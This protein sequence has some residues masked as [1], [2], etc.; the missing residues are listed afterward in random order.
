MWENADGDPMGL[1]LEPRC[2]G[3]WPPS[4]E[5][6]VPA[7]GC[8]ACHCHSYRPLSCISLANGDG[9]GPVRCEVARECQGRNVTRRRHLLKWSIPHNSAVFYRYEQWGLEPL[10]FFC[11]RVKNC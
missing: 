1:A 9:G 2:C 7:Y 6:A 8:G 11:Q 5:F 3:M 4:T 10:A